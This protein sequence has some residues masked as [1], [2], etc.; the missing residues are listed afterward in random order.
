M[1]RLDDVLIN[2]AMKALRMLEVHLFVCYDVL[3]K[4]MQ[5]MHEQ[6]APSLAHAVLFAARAS[7]F[8]H[9]PVHEGCAQGWCWFTHGIYVLLYTECGMEFEAATSISKTD[10]WRTCGRH[11]IQHLHRHGSS[12]SY[13]SARPYCIK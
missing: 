13:H 11:N 2:S 1:K 12:L 6:K 10:A 5:G 9:V 3:C 4:T 8:M 7:E